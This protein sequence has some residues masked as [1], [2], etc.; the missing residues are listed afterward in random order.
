MLDL[1]FWKSIKQAV[2]QRSGDIKK[3]E[4][5]SESMIQSRLWELV[6]EVVGSYSAEK[7]QNSKPDVLLTHLRVSYAAP[8]AGM[9]R[10]A[11]LG[12]VFIIG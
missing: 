10:V 9:F 3:L 12:I 4:N 1:G 11:V 6:K 7:I 2:R 8:S 5:Q